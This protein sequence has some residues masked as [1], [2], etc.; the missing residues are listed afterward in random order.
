MSWGAMFVDSDGVP[1]ATPDS[2]PMSLVEKRVFNRSGA[3]VDIIQLNYDKPVIVGIHSNNNKVIGSITRS[4]NDGAT[5]IQSKMI[6]GNGPYD[7]T[8]Y[9]FST[10]LQPTVPFG[11][12]IFNASGQ[13]IQTNETKVM[14][15]PVR[16]GTPG[17][18][19]SGYNVRTTLAGRWVVIPATTG[20][21]TAVI[22]TGG[23]GRPFQQPITS[24][25]SFDGANTQIYSGA[26]DTPGG[27]ATN[28]TYT[29]TRDSV[30]VIDVSGF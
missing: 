27:A 8:V 16:L 21:V 4:S 24:F 26:W 19:E 2:T 5:A 15:A 12:N 7:L 22:Q 28:I 1:W 30:Y 13:C 11:I 17:S 9:I 23:G 20:Y 6:T 25:A 10:Q 29:N 14:P 3:G 18:D